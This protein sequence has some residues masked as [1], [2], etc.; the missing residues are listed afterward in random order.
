[1]VQ[2]Y[3]FFHN[4][5]HFIAHYSVFTR[6]MSKFVPQLTSGHPEQFLH[7]NYLYPYL[8]TLLALLVAQEAEKPPW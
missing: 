1:M 6:K 2:R 8:C 5:A 3:I 4:Y 7:P